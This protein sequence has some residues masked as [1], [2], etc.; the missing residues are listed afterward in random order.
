MSIHDNLKQLRLN[1]GLTQEQVA[2]KVGLTRQAIS[3]YEAGRTLPDIE[4]LQ[5]LAR[6]YA[7]DLDGI[8][9]GEQKQLQA[10]RRYRQALTGLLAILLMLTTLSSALLCSAHHFFAIGGGM[11]AAE[12]PLLKA[13]QRLMRGWELADTAILALSSFGFAALLLYQ[14]CGKCRIAAGQLRR[15]IIFAAAALLIP[16]LF[17]CLDAVFGLIDYL[18]TPLMLLMR[19]VIFMLLSIALDKLLHK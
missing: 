8:V 10:A 7:T 15:G 4:M 14:V 1:S 3:G 19:L 18:I 12:L 17:S 9:Y 11:S 2:E 5:Q 16:A 6:V 13:H